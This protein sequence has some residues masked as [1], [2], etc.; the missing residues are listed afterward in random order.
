MT[1]KE[2][3]KILDKCAKDSDTEKAHSVADD[4]LLEFIADGNISSAYKQVKKWYA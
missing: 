4:A 1:K 2:L 3:L